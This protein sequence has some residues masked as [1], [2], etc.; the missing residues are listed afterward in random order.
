VDI[1]AAV[2]SNSGEGDWSWSRP[3][4]QFMRL[5]PRESLQGNLLRSGITVPRGSLG[6][7][8]CDGEITEV[9]KPG[10]R[11]TE[12]IV[13]RF[14]N[15]FSQRLERTFVYLIDT[16]PLLMGF[17][18]PRQQGGT[19]T[20]FEVAVD[21]RLRDHDKAAV[22]AAIA[23]L[24]GARDSVSTRDVYHQLRPRILGLVTPRLQ[25]TTVQAGDLEAT[26]SDLRRALQEAIADPIGL[27]LNVTISASNTA[28]MVDVRVGDAPTPTTKKCVGCTADIEA[29]RKFC[30]KCGVEQ[31][32]ITMPGRSCTKCGNLVPEGRKFC[33]KCGEAFVAPPAEST[34]IYTADKQQIEADVVLRAE[35]P[36]DPD[37]A[38]RI[39][40]M[41][42]AALAQHLRTLRYDELVASN[43]FSKLEQALRE[44]LNA[45]GA[46]SGVSITDV[47]LLD[48][49][50]KGQEWLLGA[51]AEIE[52]A[53][54][55]N[56][57]GREWLVADTDAV[58]LRGEQLDLKR[59]EYELELRRLRVDRDQAF[60]IARD[61][62]DD[63]ERHDLLAVRAQR[64]ELETARAM[65]AEAQADRLARQALLDET[66]RLDV[67]D[68]DRDSN[69]TIALDAAA[70]RQQR[71]LRTEDQADALTN[72]ALAQERTLQ[73]TGFAREN[74]M[75]DIRFERTRDTEADDHRRGQQIVQSRHEMGLEREVAEH[76]AGLARQAMT[77]GA[78]R[79]R[80]ETDTA[81]Y[82]ARSKVDTDVYGRRTNAE[83]EREDD[84][85]RRDIS[86]DDD[87]R[88]EQLKVE[89]MRQLAEMDALISEQDAARELRAKQ[90][91][92]DNLLRAAQAEQDHA[93]RMRQSLAGRSLEEALAMQASELDAAVV[94][95]FAALKQADADAA[96]TVAAAKAKEEM[97]ER[98][99]AQQAAQ[100]ESLAAVQQSA[101]ANQQ[102]MFMQM[103]QMM[104]SQNNTQLAAMSTVATAAVG[105]QREL[106]AARNAAQQAG[107]HSALNIAQ[108][109]MGNMAQ[110]AAASAGAPRVAPIQAESAAPAS[111]TATAAAAP[112]AKSIPK[113]SAPPN[114]PSCAASIPPDEVF[115]G[116]CG[117]RCQ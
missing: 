12:N 113:A 46:A 83:F 17:D 102:Q 115:C 30:G 82:S 89:K 105:G 86:F 76:D 22:A 4:D 42:A 73:Q 103:M 104:Q 48:V 56:S 62:L 36:Q 53:M 32:V 45:A 8:M 13:D 44:T 116:T 63:K 109:A 57:L 61:E 55:A 58:N 27:E 106:E 6:A 87:A 72:A 26:A 1:S 29:S 43:G 108:Q 78:E 7:V 23:G 80:L 71:T 68:A 92:A 84:R 94:T 99:L 21:L 110:V 93:L 64:M 75:S 117:A 111:A 112:A 95:G 54:Q 51:R 97:L 14:T 47:T 2:A 9:L 100:G 31:P 37:L 15:L 81:A 38:A 96:S 35:G 90:A 59:L 88:R 41:V 52:R 107:S 101:A 19:S 74:E 34:P 69:R 39:K 49:R 10:F 5:V 28:C 20:S 79:Q 85:A 33:G 60:A 98:L 16:K 25:A 24:L 40:P 18:V 67:A 65:D 66:A 91:E 3:P 11:T 114:C 77:L 70:R 50:S